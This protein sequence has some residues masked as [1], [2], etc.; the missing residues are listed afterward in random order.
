MLPATSHEYGVQI[1]VWFPTPL[2]E[3]LSGAELEAFL[4]AQ[5][6]LSSEYNADIVT[7]FPFNGLGILEKVSH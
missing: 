7:T 3:R 5:I 2:Q 1:C 6:S 4:A